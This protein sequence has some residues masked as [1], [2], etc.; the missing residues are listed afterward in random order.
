MDFAKK[1]G[2]MD[3]MPYLCETDHITAALMNAKLLRNHTVAMGAE[4]CDYWYVG[5]R[6]KA[7]KEKA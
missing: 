3:I 6:S 1:H 7:T 2:Y 5:S 4:S